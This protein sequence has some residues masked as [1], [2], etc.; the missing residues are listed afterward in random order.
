MENL[1]EF[2]IAGIPLIVVIFAL[3]EEV[4]AWGVTGKV[5]RAVALALG[6]ILAVLYQLALAIPA[7]LMGWL[8]VV[9]VGLIYGLSASGAYNFLDSRFPEKV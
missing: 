7:D 9:V 6:V 3:V 2:V 4:K 5:L 8:T 1:P